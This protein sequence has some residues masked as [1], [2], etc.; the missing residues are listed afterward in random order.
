MVSCKIQRSVSK[1]VRSYAKVHKLILERALPSKSVARVFVFFFVF[2][3]PLRTLRP[4]PST[5]WWPR[6]L[7]RWLPQKW[8]RVWRCPAHAWFVGALRPVRGESTGSVQAR[9]TRCCLMS[10]TPCSLT[11]TWLGPSRLGPSR[12]QQTRARPSASGRHATPR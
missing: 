9:R 5:G 1:I 10:R 6:T 12:L 8:W 2:V 7:L 4:E 3:F 11:Q